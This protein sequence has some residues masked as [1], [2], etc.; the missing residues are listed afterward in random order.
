VIWV[1]FVLIFEAFG[2]PPRREILADG[3]ELICG[4]KDG[5]D[6]GCG[7]GKWGCAGKLWPALRRTAV[8]VTGMEMRGCGQLVAGVRARD[9]FVWSRRMDQVE[10]FR[11]R[12]GE[13]Y[14]RPEGRG[15]RRACVWGFCISPGERDLVYI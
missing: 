7:A 13:F 12:A 8:Q 2:G 11:A 10:L 15:L 4:D 3:G 14:V 5:A 1:I 6:P 9:V